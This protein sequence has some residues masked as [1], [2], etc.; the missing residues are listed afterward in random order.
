MTLEDMKA[1]DIHTV[2]R[3]TLV[4]IRDVSI[5]PS[6]SREE[7][8]RSFLEQIKNPYVFKCGNVVV[9]T[10]FANKGVKLI[11]CLENYIRNR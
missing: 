10:T 4:N 7:R 6:L 2:D 9:K 11:D 8:M 3:D 1:V 5:D